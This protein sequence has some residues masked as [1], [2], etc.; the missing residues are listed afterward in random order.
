MMRAEPSAPVDQPLGIRATLETR[1]A[2]FT[3]QSPRVEMLRRFRRNRLAVLGAGSFGLMLLVALAAPILAPGS[4]F[5]IG[6]DRLAEPSVRHPFGT[7]NLGRDVFTGVV[8]GART[9]LMVGLGSVAIS[10]IIGILIGAVA[11]FYGGWLDD[12]MMRISEI[13]LVI[14]RFFLALVVV[15]IFGANLIGI[16]LVIAVLSWP[17]IARLLRAEFLGLKERQFVTAA[18]AAGAG[19][20]RLIFRELL[21]NALPPVV[22]A[23][24]LQV[25][26]SILLEAGL[27]FLG[28][29]DPNAVSWGLLLNNSQQFIRRAWW[30]AVFPGLAIFVTT[31]GL[32][33]LADGLNDALNPRLKRAA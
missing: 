7:D 6:G 9:S 12:L 13:F 27:S 16:I 17:E 30:M 2:R 1:D 26:G 28:L 14:P 20:G 18:R 23:A 3:G 29:G 24:A 22:V 25:A 8:H 5:D 10:A 31:L 21:P 11:G 4:P 15:A 19:S 32:S 33:L